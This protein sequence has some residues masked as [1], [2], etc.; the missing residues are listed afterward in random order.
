MSKLIKKM[1]AS[2]DMLSAGEMISAQDVSSMPTNNNRSTALKNYKLDDF[3]L[4][5]TIGTGR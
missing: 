4:I 2:A 5:K 3:D 1:S